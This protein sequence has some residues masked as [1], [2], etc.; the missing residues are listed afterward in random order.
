MDASL[1]WTATI[2]WNPFN[3]V[4]NIKEW[5]RD[6]EDMIN[7]EKYWVKIQ[8]NLCG[9]RFVLK[10]IRKKGKVETGFRRCLCDNDRDFIIRE[11]KLFS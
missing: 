5:M 9:E 11:E 8:C 4:N 7:E 1:K 6:G 3:P 2:V 10:G